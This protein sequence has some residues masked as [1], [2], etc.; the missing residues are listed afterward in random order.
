MPAQS[1]VH[2]ADKL[3]CADGLYCPPLR[4]SV[5]Q[6]QSQVHVAERSC[7]VH[8]STT[9]KAC[10]EQHCYEQQGLTSLSLMPGASWN[11]TS[12]R[13]SNVRNERT[14]RVPHAAH[15]S[16]WRAPAAAL[17]CSRLDLDLGLGSR[18]PLA[19]QRKQ[20]GS[21]PG[22]SVGGWARASTAARS[23]HSCRASQLPIRH[24]I[25]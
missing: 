10:K 9:S 24:R 12:G 7:A 14:K 23:A 21:S 19:P 8:K 15:A 4:T 22:V 2:V 18:P 6:A 20:T 3:S 5:M 13:L 16:P 1:Q 11:S 25:G 17:A